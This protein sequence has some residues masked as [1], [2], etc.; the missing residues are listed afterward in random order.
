LEPIV[1]GK[2][3]NPGTHIDL[4]GSYKKDMREADDDLI[5][6]SNVY[7]DNPAAVQECGDIYW[8]IKKGILKEKN[9][10]GTLADLAN[11]KCAG[12]K[13]NGEI[14]LFKSVGFALE[15][16]AAAEYL[17]EKIDS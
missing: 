15:D 12:R 8:P 16:L 14:T 9:I 3:I 1:F 13:N 6:R 4:V 10:K 11:R 7:I 2:Y 17:F 5:K